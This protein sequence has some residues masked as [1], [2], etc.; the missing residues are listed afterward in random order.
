MFR[1]FFFL[2]VKVIENYFSNKL[3]GIKGILALL[4]ADGEPILITPEKTLPEKVDW[5]ELVTAV[6]DGIKTKIS[7]DGREYLASCKWREYKK[8]SAFLLLPYDDVIKDVIHIHK[9][10]V[11]VFLIILFIEIFLVSISIKINFMPINWL[12]ESLIHLV[13]D[14]HNTEDEISYIGRAVSDVVEKNNLLARSIQEIRPAARHSVLYSLLMGPVREWGDLKALV[15]TAGIIFQFSNFFIAI[16]EF[17]KRMEHQERER[18]KS[19]LKINKEDLKCYIVDIF[20]HY[21]IPLI[22]SCVSEDISVVLET[23]EQIKNFAK[24]KYGII[25]TIGVSGVC[26]DIMQLSQSYLQAMSA[27]EYGFVLGEGNT[28]LYNDIISSNQYSL[29]YPKEEMQEV[30]KLMD[31]MDIEGVRSKIKD[32]FIEIKNRKV[33]VYVAKCIAY[34]VI[35]FLIRVMFEMKIDLTEFKHKYFNTVAMTEFKYIS[36]LEAFTNTFMDDVSEIINIKKDKRKTDFINRIIGYIEKEYYIPEFSIDYIARELNVSS[37]YLMRYFK[38]QKNI[39]ILEY[40]TELRIKKAQELLR[41]T[42]MSIKAIAVDVGYL[43]VITF[44]RNFKKLVKMNPGN[45]RS[46]NQ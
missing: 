43:E 29:W 17:N 34:D 37:G 38:E 12:K 39:T 24:E 4:N 21:K 26:N 45:Y 46:V 9:K 28:I 31:V 7:L 27:V 20:D 13:G 8:V 36:E 25:V 23:I 32:I 35:N 22:F 19:E 40:V 30:E 18:F 15:S 14:K 41:E 1:L 6:S 33:P 2:D 3:D 5:Q 11:G 16:I 42:D 44:N 10:A